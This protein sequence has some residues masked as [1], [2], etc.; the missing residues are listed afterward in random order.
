MFWC[1]VQAELHIKLMVNVS[2]AK[3]KANFYLLT[4][5][6][7]VKKV[8]AVYKNPIL[9][10][11]MPTSHSNR[12]VGGSVLPVTFLHVACTERYSEIR[13][14]TLIYVINSN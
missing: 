3:N 6:S 9:E 4:Y 14:G 1:E 5:Y 12:K 8:T 2:T 7:A 10:T 13:P 11:F